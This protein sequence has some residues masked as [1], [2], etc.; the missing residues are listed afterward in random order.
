MRIDPRIRVAYLV[1]IAVGVFFVRQLAP[2]SVLLL[3]QG[4]LWLALGLGARRLLR[5]VTK[6]WGFA[7]FI[8]LSFAL[9]KEDPALDRWIH[10]EVLP[11]VHVAINVTGALVG[12][13]MLVR[14]VVVVLASQVARAG[15]GRAIAAGLRDIH[16]PP[17]VAAS[18]DAVLVLLGGEEQIPGSG[19]GR[20]GGRGG[21]GGGGGGGRG[22]GRGREGHG[23]E[24]GFWAS[25]K[26]L[27]RGDVEPIV[28]RL[29]RQMDRAERH[30]VEQGV[31]ERA[32][33]LVRD[34]GVIAGVSLTMLGIK[35]LKVLPAIPFAPGHKL[36][37]LTP[38]YIV[39]S[40][41]TRSRFGA[42]LTGL[43]MGTVAFL[44]GDGRYGI[45]EIL[46]HVT[47]GLICDLTV[48]LLMR[49][50]R[51]PG[52]VLWTLEGALIGAGRFAT[53]FT[54][55]LAVQPPSIAWAILIPGATVHTTFGALSGY[56]SYHLVKAIARLRARV[57]AE[58]GLGTAAGG[59]D[60][61]APPAPAGE[62]PIIERTHEQAGYR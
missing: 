46:K 4:V 11:G 36:I 6:L 21:G 10:P 23:A 54:I 2:L 1:A 47:P 34:V 19:M 53:I 49:G 45:F 58:T 12:V 41:L 40:L 38:L 24:E 16:V 60:A 55:T 51:E 56:V 3:A 26:R 48:P 15:D 35:A 50:G 62:P 5:Q 57:S 28:R 61:T 9:T 20:G 37:I 17:I 27:G 52:P 44:L 29:E 59:G 32:G 25:V 31:G 7:L 18:I 42:T 39:A 33:S 8:L 43:V 13:A 22:G 30:A 14:I